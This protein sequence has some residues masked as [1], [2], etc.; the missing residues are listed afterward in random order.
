MA[1]TDSYVPSRDRPHIG[2]AS[3]LDSDHAMPIVMGTIA[4]RF[5]LASIRIDFGLG[6]NIPA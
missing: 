4:V 1:M 3:L 6:I 5:Q 2:C